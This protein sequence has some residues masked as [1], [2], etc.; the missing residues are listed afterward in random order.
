MTYSN[1]IVLLIF[2]I[3][4]VSIF[5]EAFESKLHKSIRRT[6]LISNFKRLFAPTSEK[7]FTT[8]YGTEITPKYIFRPKSLDDLKDIVKNAKTNGK[9]IRCV[10]QGHTWASLSITKD[11]LVIVNNLNQIVEIKKTDKYGWTVTVL[12]GTQTKT[13]EQALLNNKP[14]LAF[15]S[16]VVPDYFSASGLIAVGAHGFKTGGPGVSDLVVKLQIVT[17]DGELQ[18]FSNEKDP[19]EFNT[20]RLNLGLLGIIYSVTFRVEPLFNLRSDNIVVPIKDWLKP[21]NLKKLV[22]DSD[23]IE[24]IYWPFNK[25]HIDLSSDDL[26]IKQFIRTQDP[27]TT[28]KTALDSIVD[29]ALLQAA[30]TSAEFLLKHT[31][32]TPAVKGAQW[33]LYKKSF[34]SEVLIAP[35][36]IHFLN[37]LDGIQADDVSFAF[38]IDPD[39]TNVATE[40]LFL[41]QKV[42]EYAKKG[43]F[44]VNISTSARII[45]ASA[46]LLSPNFDSDPNAYYCF[47]EASTIK[48]TPSWVE[49]FN[50]VSARWI[51][52]YQARPHWAKEWESL[53]GIKPFLRTGLGNRLETFEKVRAKYD[54]NKT[55]FDNDS[56]KQIFYG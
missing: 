30:N 14:P 3:L 28:T 42:A 7:S 43:K 8:W 40:L 2:I 16:M 23:S 47:I 51:S 19:I 45:R 38:K 15:E 17:G 50:E 39:F 52:N 9:K 53:A 22:Y 21:A 35:E 33:L 27:P 11:Y 29:G 54:S 10:G 12:A 26:W 48:N 56:L 5:F 55:F 1:R 41:I 31:E 34:K 6:E 46:A 37:G 20:A 13:I 44:P 25:G 24:F 4:I 49:F 18:E 32:L 36:A